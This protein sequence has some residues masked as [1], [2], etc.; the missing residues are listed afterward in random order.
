MKRH[1]IYKAILLIGVC[2]AVCHVGGIMIY[3]KEGDVFFLGGGVQSITL[4]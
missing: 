1:I 2:V 4:I 3:A